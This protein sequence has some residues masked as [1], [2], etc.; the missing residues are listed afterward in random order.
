MMRAI[1]EDITNRISSASILKFVAAILA[2]VVAAGSIYVFGFLVYLG[3]AGFK[4]WQEVLRDHFAAII[5]LPGAA[6]VSF[7]IVVFLRQTEGPIEFEGLG[8]KFRGAAGQVVMWIA[9]FLTI[10]AAIR[11][12]WEIPK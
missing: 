9:C 3:S 6:A 2:I 5:G 11:M 12:C 8:F 1:L 4:Y 10:T 7:A